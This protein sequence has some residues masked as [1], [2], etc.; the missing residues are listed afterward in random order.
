MELRFAA[1]VQV[2]DHLLP[3]WLRRFERQ[4]LGIMPKVFVGNNP[5][6]VK[7]VGSGE[8]PIEIMVSNERCCDSFE[9]D[10]ILDDELVVVVRPSPPWAQQRISPKDLPNEPFIS[11]EDG[12]ATKEIIEQTLVGMGGITLNM[13]I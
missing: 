7:A 8:M 11:R 12:S 10:P 4:M 5:Q 2:G 13:W 3:Q 9:S 1:C 6:V